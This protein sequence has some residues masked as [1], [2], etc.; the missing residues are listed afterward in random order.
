[1]AYYLGKD[2]NVYW[3]TEHERFVVSGTA[4][5]ST[6][7]SSL[8]AS[9]GGTAAAN[10]DITGGLMYNR[11]EGITTNT[12]ISDITGV[13]FTPGATNEDVSFMGKNTNLS[14]KVKN[15]FSLS[16]NAYMIPEFTDKVFGKTGE[17]VR[18]YTNK[19]V[20]F[21]EKII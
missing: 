12:L 20:S 21:S 9:Q 11:S 18:A 16:I 14:A 8:A 15:E 2:V 3:T 17:M 7:G 13:D 4:D 19:K 10:S 6:T 5:E 1:M